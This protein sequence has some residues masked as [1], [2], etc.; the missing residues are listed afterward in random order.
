[1]YFTTVSRNL[2]NDFILR[3]DFIM[4][5]V[6]QAIE[7]DHGFMLIKD[8]YIYITNVLKTGD[9]FLENIR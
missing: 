8:I 3:V 6:V 4:D 2:V 5:I 9:G 7:V 1:M